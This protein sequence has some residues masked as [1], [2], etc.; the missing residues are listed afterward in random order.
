MRSTGKDTMQI[1]LVNDDGVYAGGILALAKALSA[2]HDVTVIAPDRERSATSHSITLDRPITIRQIFRDELP[3][4]AFFSI[5]GTPVDC[6][7]VAES[8]PDLKPDLLVSGINNGANLGGDVAYSGTVHAALEAAIYGLPAIALSLRVAPHQQRTD[9]VPRFEE[10]A[11]MSA[12]IIDSISLRELD[13]IIYNINFPSDLSDCPDEVRV[14]PQGI[15]VYSSVFQKQTDPFGRE[16]YWLY[17][18]DHDSE[19]NDEHKTDVY[20]SNKGYTTCTPMTWNATS[21]KL[22]G[23]AEK[24]FAS[25]RI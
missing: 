5:N 4:V 22:L 3:N 10:A 11:R 18:V 17:A 14:C 12:H 6:V 9:M 19:Y 25:I 2:N 15:S 23:S 24:Q 8:M 16:V 1:V 21:E 13:G 20:W 7:H